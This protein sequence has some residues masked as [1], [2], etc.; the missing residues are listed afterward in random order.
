MKGW[1]RNAK[2]ASAVG[3]L[4]LIALLW[5]LGIWCDWSLETRFIAVLL[6]MLLWVLT[7]MVGQVV[8]NKAGNLLEGVLR[9][10]ADDAVIN[11]GS[12]KRAEVTMLRQRLLAAV[13]T[14][15]TSK[16]GKASGRAALYELPWYMIIGHP[17][18]GK[19][20]AILQSGLTFPFSDKHGVQG[21][22]GTRNCDW[23]FSTEGI[24]LDT[25]GRYATQSED[26]VEW[27]EFLKL[28]KRHRSRA[29]VNGI[30]VAVSL[31]ELTQHQS[32]G[33]EIYA[34]QVRERIHEITHT[35]GRQVPIYLVFTKLDLLSGFNQ[36]FQDCAEDERS[37]VWGATFSANQ[38][39]DFDV[40]TVVN[41]QFELLAK[42]LVQAG[43]ERLLHGGSQNARSAHF[44]FPIEFSNLKAGVVRFVRLLTEED[45]YHA[46][47]LLRGFYFTSALQEGAPRIVAA[48]RIKS[49]FGIVGGQGG[50][51]SG[52]AASYSFFLRNLFREVIFPDQHLMSNQGA[53]QRRPWRLAGMAAGLLSLCVICG[54]WTWSYIGNQDL[55]Q[56]LAADRV[57]AHK[58]AAS[59]E[60]H[61][62]LA[63]LIMV[64]KD[65]E[66]LQSYRN[67]GAPWQLGMGL[68]QGRE[69]ETSL[70][71]EYFAGLKDVMLS[72]VRQNLET[73][74]AALKQPV[75]VPSVPAPKP[76]PVA[77]P[78]T[79]APK[80]EVKSKP[81]AK[82]HAPKR[83]G[84]SALPNIQISQNEPVA[85][86]YRQVAW[87]Q[88]AGGRGDW[89]HAEPV[90][91]GFAG[92]H[93]MP[94]ADVVPASAVAN[95]A[96]AAPAQDAA[97]PSGDGGRQAQL[98]VAYNALK[99]YLMLHDSKYMEEAQLS[100]Q[101]P[102]YWRPWLADHRG[103][104]AESE[105]M[106]LAERLI[107]FY[108][109]QIHE[110]DLPLIDND[111]NVVSSARDVLRASFKRLSGPER[112]FNAIRAHANT[113]Y[114]P[115]T[116]GQ[117]L[118]NRDLDVVAGSQM[119]EGA[120]TRQAWN[121]YVSKAIDDASRG[122]ISGDDWVLAT[123]LTENLGQDGNVDK[124]R[125]ELTNLY[126][127][128]Y[129]AQWKKF[130]MGVAVRD[131][132]NSAQAASAMTRLADPKTSPV[133]LILTR[134]A[135]ETSWDNPSELQNTLRSAGKSVLEKTAEF[136]RG[137][138][139]AKADGQTN[140]Y[141]QVGGYFAGVAQLTRGDNPPI[142]G[143][144][145]QL[146]KIKAKLA[147]MA[148][149]DDSGAQAAQALKATLAGSGSEL[150]DAMGFVDNTLLAPVSADTREMVRPLLVRP[151]TQ[152]YSALVGS[153]TAGI[154]QAWQTEVMPQWR[155]I[156][157]KYPFANSSNVASVD[158]IDR[159]A[160]ANS[161]VF[162]QFVSKHLDGLVQRQGDNLVPRTWGG[163]GVHFSP[164]FLSAAPKLAALGN[165]QGQGGD[166]AA[167]FE[168]QALPT[169]GLAEIAF[170]LD[171]QELHYRNGAQVWQPFSWPGNGQAGARIQALTYGGSAVVVGSQT[172]HMGFL[173]LLASA[174]VEQQSAGGAV[175][176][177]TIKKDGGAV[178]TVRFNFRSVS[179]LNPLQLTQ[180][181]DLTLPERI[182][183]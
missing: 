131:F 62:R 38:G 71:R 33:F 23:F 77:K 109:S 163:M 37:Q 139:G 15:K 122:Q 180:L 48:G 179:G 4:I 177:W 40:A 182:T 170:M 156:G 64:Q 79:P 16:L 57:A 159:F 157:G 42:G 32:E 138:S 72:P 68:Y 84:G 149:G 85:S 102:R 178:D 49:L 120:F 75:E 121:D 67:N 143:Y 164:A 22:G 169:P 175:L 1:L 110:T 12:E 96:P 144:L 129:I 89:W 95:A 134:V 26:R 47:P 87:Q 106:P 34:R 18:A 173:R 7:L 137:D 150:A 19:S 111:P 92:F 6:V 155:Q 50:Q 133:K 151:L 25:A 44:A 63:A 167:R 59:G 27:L 43:E 39:A 124:N 86:P 88:A 56:R 69:V 24:L 172:G 65:L 158:E 54:L 5:L 20:S 136:I 21:V 161:G 51:G 82:P 114:T 128:Q 181:R 168:I 176:S 165:A 53:P 8:K 117:I 28:L 90:S 41:K 46:R 116:V 123:K 132:A 127:A 166:A 148:S 76:T 73:A 115:L 30:L 2:V 174:K 107:A 152:T 101:L 78:A 91:G 146:G 93:A 11:A 108:V 112:V 52:S 183:M 94:V 99:T 70:R 17:A 154:N 141:G 125:A 9:K 58:L 98:D 142:N 104:Y 13:E 118:D 97:A 153:A 83:G 55:L 45:P 35:F 80:P 100:D 3:F 160:H 74:L 103:Q 31:P 60:L 119:V 126:R 81:K 130:L 105:I 14:L 140:Q 147:A 61:D 145:D 66:E 171:G 162:D 135:Q 113:R 29:P 36:F 10:Q